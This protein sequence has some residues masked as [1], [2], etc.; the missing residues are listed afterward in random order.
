M[1][2]RSKYG[3]YGWASLHSQVWPIP[4]KRHTIVESTHLAPDTMKILRDQCD[5][6]I[7]GIAKSADTVCALV[8]RRRV[9]DEPSMKPTLIKLMTMLYEGE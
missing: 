3:R 6:Y 9:G 2:L 8:P 5:Q 7:H 1:P 4:G